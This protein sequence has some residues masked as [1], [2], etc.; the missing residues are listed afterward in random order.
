MSLGLSVEEFNYL[1][2][3]QLSIKNALELYNSDYETP[4]KIGCEGTCSGKCEGDCATT[5]SGD[6][7]GKCSNTCA[8]NCKDDC[9]VNCTGTCAKTS[10]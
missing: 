5:C 9:A 2:E 1:H 10:I 6:C 8:G 3:A 7:S 4:I